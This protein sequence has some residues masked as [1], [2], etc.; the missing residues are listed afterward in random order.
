M[1]R[2]S[3]LLLFTPLLALA[4]EEHGEHAGGDPLLSYKW[5]NFAI[6]AACIGYA[7]VKYLIPMLAERSAGIQKDLA[8]SRSA[9]AEA[10]ARIKNLES[11]LGNF[12][13]ELRSIRE[14]MAA[15]RDAEAKR[16][17]GQTA[18]LLDKLNQQKANELA[19]LTKVAEAQLR[20]FTAEKALELAGARL[21]ATG[22]D[23]AQHRLV[24]AF[25]AD[26][27]QLETR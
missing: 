26:L 8:E 12:D 19:N 4:A 6:L 10:E 23:D 16:I 9:V 20:A 22:Q 17:A 14:R 7:V 25:V 1:P 2:T 24:A 3:F 11:K 5:I 21:S 13:G 15:E 18:N 27:K